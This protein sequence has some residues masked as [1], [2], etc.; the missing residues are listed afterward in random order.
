MPWLYSYKPCKGWG[1]TIHGDGAEI[2]A[3]PRLV[4]DSREFTL[5]AEFGGHPNRLQELPQLKL[6][7]GQQQKELKSE[8]I[9]TSAP[10]QWVRG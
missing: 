5:V 2:S 1:A 3:D 8:L 7:Q 6:V 9:T 4:Q 10:W